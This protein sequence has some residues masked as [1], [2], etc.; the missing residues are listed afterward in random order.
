[1]TNLTLSQRLAAGCGYEPPSPTCEQLWE[2]PRGDLGTDVEVTTCPG[3]TTMLPEVIEA[4][5]A[6]THWEKG[7][8]EAFCGGEPTEQLV[9][10]VEIFD[11]AV[12]QYAYW[13]ATPSKK[14]GGADDVG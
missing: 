2:P 12:G 1:M 3:Y 9:V 8:L 4:A 5:R 13:R 11:A 6:R 7:Q 14:G 10:A